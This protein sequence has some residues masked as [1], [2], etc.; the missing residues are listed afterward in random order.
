MSHVLFGTCLSIIY[1][2]FRFNSVS[3]TLSGNPSQTTVWV[4]SQLMTQPSKV[5]RELVSPGW[6]TPES[7]KKGGSIGMVLRGS[8]QLLAMASDG[9]KGTAE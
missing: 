2:K 8:E 3:H 5:C 9:H 7:S 1:M 6:Q 4:K